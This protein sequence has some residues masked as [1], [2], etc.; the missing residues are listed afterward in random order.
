MPTD[1]SGELNLMIFLW[2]KF[3]AGKGCICHLEIVPKPSNMSLAGM[4][5][6][7]HTFMQEGVKVAWNH[8]VQFEVHGICSVLQGKGD[9]A[10]QAVK[11]AQSREVCRIGDYRLFLTFFD[12]KY[13]A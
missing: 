5:I 13:S 1:M 2:L 4:K 6:R 3:G 8:H 10:I 11:I 12:G 7:A 9:F